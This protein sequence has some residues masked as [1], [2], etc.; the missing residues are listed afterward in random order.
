MKAYLLL[1]AIILSSVISQKSTLVFTADNFVNGIKINGKDLDLKGVT[2][3]NDWRLLST[4]KLDYPLRE[5]DIIS[6]D[7]SNGGT[8]S[9]GNPANLLA[10]ITYFNNVNEEKTFLTNLNDWTYNNGSPVSSYGSLDFDSNYNNARIPGALH[11]YSLR[12][13]DQQVII[14]GKIPFENEKYNNMNVLQTICTPG[15]YSVE[16]IHENRTKSTF[17][18]NLVNKAGKTIKQEDIY[19]FL[20]KRQIIVKVQDINHTVVKENYDINYTTVDT[21]FLFEIFLDK[22]IRQYQ[23]VKYDVENQR[24]EL[25]ITKS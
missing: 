14:D 4:I 10:S 8:F 3:L 6:F 16:T 22:A 7:I 23:S 9:W 11:I 24:I 1:F 19:S 2:N 25:I 5:G 17:V 13:Y 12:L 18:C 15:D 21:Y 20:I